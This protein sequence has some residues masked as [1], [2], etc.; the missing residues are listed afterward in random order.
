MKRKMIKH[1]P[2]FCIAPGPCITPTSVNCLNCRNVDVN[3]KPP[4]YKSKVNK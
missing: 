1:K 2:Y 3:R 4:E